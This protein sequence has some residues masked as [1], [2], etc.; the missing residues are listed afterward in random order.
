MVGRYRQCQF[1]VAEFKRELA[2]TQEGSRLPA[3]VIRVG[4][5]AGEPL[6]DLVDAATIVED[7]I[8]ASCAEFI[9]GDDEMVPVD[10]ELEL[11]IRLE[12]RCEI[13]PHHRA[14]DHVLESR[15]GRIPDGGDVGAP[16]K[17]FLAQMRPK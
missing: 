7:L 12:R 14:G 17:T 1:V 9:V 2:T 5:H 3:V 13:D 10:A 15:A 4:R 6:R 11:F 16:G 8:A